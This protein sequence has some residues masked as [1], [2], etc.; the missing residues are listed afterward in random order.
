[1]PLRVLVCD[2]D[3]PIRLMVRELCESRGF[4]V[5]EANEGGQALA[6]ATAEDFDLLITDFLIPKKDG[7]E[8]IRA[9]RM[10]P[11]RRGLTVI[12]MSAISRSQILDHDEEFGPDFYLNKPIQPKKLIRLIDR[13]LPM[14]EAARRQAKRK[15]TT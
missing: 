2:D 1:M 10:Q 7:L 6:L 14:L 5:T 3:L 4:D 15:K 12:L 8:L 13:L 11:E 9:L